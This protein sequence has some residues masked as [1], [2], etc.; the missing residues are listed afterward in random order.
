MLPAEG[1]QLVHSPH[2]RANIMESNP[3]RPGHE[4]GLLTVRPL[5]I[6]A[7]PNTR[8]IYTR[9]ALTFSSEQ[10]V[11]VRKANQQVL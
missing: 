11:P 8:K 9:Y 6:N 10:N 2:V 1:K 7:T 3:R 4:F 5:R